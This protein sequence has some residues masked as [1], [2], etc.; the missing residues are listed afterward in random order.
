MKAFAITKCILDRYHVLPQLYCV[1]MKAKKLNEKKRRKKISIKKIE[2]LEYK[3]FIKDCFENQPSFH[4][5]FTRRKAKT[6]LHVLFKKIP[7]AFTNNSG[8][9]INQKSREFLNF[10]CDFPGKF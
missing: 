5:T 3:G 7:I 4:D 1:K 6:F 8:D 2:S 9:I 10:S